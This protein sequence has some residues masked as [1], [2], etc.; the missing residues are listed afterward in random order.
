MLREFIIITTYIYL[1]SYINIPI[2]Q[3]SFQF[4]YKV[5]FITMCIQNCILWR[6]SKKNR[7][8]FLFPKTFYSPVQHKTGAESERYR[9]GH[10]HLHMPR[11][12]FVWQTGGRR[13]ERFFTL[14]HTLSLS[15]FMHVLAW[16]IWIVPL[17]C[18]LI[19]WNVPRSIFLP[20]CRF[21]NL[22]C[23][24]YT[25]WRWHWFC[26]WA[27]A[28]LTSIH[29]KEWSGE[30]R[31]PRNRSAG[32]LHIISPLC[33]FQILSIMMMLVMWRAW[34]HECTSAPYKEVE[35]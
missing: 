27:C 18:V 15:K 23:A 35:L 30:R 28:A 14:I 22:S 2:S 29:G 16:L 31:G 21:P 12:H 6:E 32:A 26:A 10:R 13:T 11:V 20:A 5:Q 3:L 19:M 33:K 1:Y 7:W 4:H 25:R 9:H 8:I 24:I 17:A 34:M